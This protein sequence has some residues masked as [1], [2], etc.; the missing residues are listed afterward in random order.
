MPSIALWALHTAACGLRSELLI[1]RPYLQLLA[2][3]HFNHTYLHAQLGVFTWVA[4]GEGHYLKHGLWLSVEELVQRD[5]AV[6][7][8]QGVPSPLRRLTLPKAE[9]PELLRLL[10]KEQISRAHLMPTYDNIVESLKQ[11]WNL[12]VSAE[13]G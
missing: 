8:G 7:W 1:D 3:R 5:G 4:G 10:W 12:Q 2:P 13:A 9:V 6:L 11:R